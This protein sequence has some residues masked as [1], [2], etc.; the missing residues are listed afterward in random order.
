ML[1]DY[2]I[3]F[4][5]FGN[6]QLSRHS[7]QTASLHQLYNS[8]SR[9]ESETRRIVLSHYSCNSSEQIHRLNLL[10]SCKK[11]KATYFN[12][13]VTY[14]WT[15]FLWGWVLCE[16]MLP[17]YYISFAIIIQMENKRLPHLSLKRKMLRFINPEYSGF[18]TFNIS[19]PSA[20]V[21]YSITRTK[22]GTTIFFICWCG[23]DET[24]PYPVYSQLPIRNRS[25]LLL[26]TFR[27]RDV[28][29]SAKQVFT[30]VFS[31]MTSF[32]LFFC[33]FLK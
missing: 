25:R 11:G 6:V 28:Q 12:V 16:S 19:Y 20:Q 15:F 9:N 5:L 4:F 2:W 8:T 30:A 27:F 29:S 33:F 21:L 10:K 31:I 18:T 3:D 32:H 26:I 7:S 24:I 22:V 17:S 23:P 13:L 1:S 14:R